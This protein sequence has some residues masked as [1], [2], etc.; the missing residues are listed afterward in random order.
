MNKVADKKFSDIFHE[1]EKLYKEKNYLESLTK[2]KEILNLNPKHIS[3]LNNIA[4]NYEKLD[5]NNEAIN[6]YEQCIQ[7]LPNESIIIHNLANAY[8]KT[9]RY[10]D[11]LP[12]LKKIINLDYKKETNH[13]KLA[14]CLFYTQTKNE[15]KNFIKLA[16]TKFPN[17]TLLNGLLGKTL[18]HLNLHKDGIKYLQ[19]STGLIEFNNNGVKYLS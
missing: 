17:N 18:L 4:L 15:T 5:D 6:Y 2:Y 11:A 16:I 10:L 14:L 12:L 1:A 3:V 7:I 8:C 19:K 13:E 9:D